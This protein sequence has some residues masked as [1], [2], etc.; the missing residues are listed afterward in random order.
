MIKELNFKL[1]NPRKPNNFDTS[2]ISGQY[3]DFNIS[4]QSLKKYLGIEN[5]NSVT[6]FGWFLN[7]NEQSKSLQQFRLQVRSHLPSNRVELYVCSDCGDISC[8]SV[9][10]QILNMGNRIVWTKFARQSEPNEISSF[11]S[12]EDLE[13]ERSSYFKALSQIK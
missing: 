3:L 13:F 9:T 8:G 11:F 2:K 12:V 4:G 5:D 10:A 6:P 1:V 7:K